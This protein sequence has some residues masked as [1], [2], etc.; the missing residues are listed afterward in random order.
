MAT[1]YED[2]GKESIS[3]RQL[4]VKKGTVLPIDINAKGG[5]AI[6]IEVITD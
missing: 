3:K 1:I 2:D 5:Q 6:M 4:R